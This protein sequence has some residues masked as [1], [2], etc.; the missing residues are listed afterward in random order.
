MGDIVIIGGPNGAGNVPPSAEQ[1]RPKP[2]SAREIL[3]AIEWSLQE[4]R[5]RLAEAE[6]EIDRDPGGT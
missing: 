3:D 1:D 5:R 6:A 2:Q 4:T